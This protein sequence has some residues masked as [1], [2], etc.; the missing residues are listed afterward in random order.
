MLGAS[1]Q[2][3]PLLVGFR[4][5]EVRTLEADP[6]HSPNPTTFRPFEWSAKHAW[7]IDIRRMLLETS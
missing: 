2:A 6:P 1:F 4:V 3:R 5:T 7:P